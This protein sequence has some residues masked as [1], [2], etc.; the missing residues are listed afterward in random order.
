MP[1]LVPFGC[2][3]EF[4]DEWNSFIREIDNMQVIQAQSM[5]GIASMSFGS[6]RWLIEIG[7]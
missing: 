5:S 7:Q 2:I 4:V 3:V 6:G 1:K